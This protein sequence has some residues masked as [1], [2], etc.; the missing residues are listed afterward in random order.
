MWGF[1]RRKAATTLEMGLLLG[2]IGI[3][4]LVSLQGVGQ[5]LNSLF[6]QVNQTLEAAGG[7][8]VPS[9]GD[10]T[11]TWDV[12][13]T[14]SV[15]AI[16][17]Y[18]VSEA[19]LPV[20]QDSLGR[21]LSYQIVG[22]SYGLSLNSQDARLSGSPTEVG[23]IAFTAEVTNG[24]QTV[25]KQFMLPVSMEPSSCKVILESGVGS[26]DG[27]YP[28]LPSQDAEDDA[29]SV[30]CDMTTDG[31]GWTHIRHVAGNYWWPYDD[32]FTCSQTHGTYQPVLTSSSIFGR[33][34]C[35]ETFGDYLFSTGDYAHWIVVSQA[36]V[37]T[38]YVNA[39]SCTQSITLKASSIGGQ[40]VTVCKRTGQPEDPWLSTR[41]HG[42]GP[43]NAAS[44]GEVHSM[45]WGENNQ[46]VWD[47]W[48]ENHD[49]INVFI[50]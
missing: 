15:T 17:S 24:T 47:Y 48:L 16:R 27:V 4:L 33:D 21:T 12:S 44:D 9:A 45:L 23:T 41:S 7:N 18:D 22:N 14:L 39:S 50:R 3:A 19:A 2:L 31:G 25:A 43:Y 1:W 34:W 49:G 5:K 29:L 32:N 37:E 30:Y 35:G 20:A 36:D 42:Y 38:G 40:T 13:P 6:G 8:I 28:I 46:D 11:L 10:G 26:E